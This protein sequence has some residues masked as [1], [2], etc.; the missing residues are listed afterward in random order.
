M[1][2]TFKHYVQ[3]LLNDLPSV[4]AG[5]LPL[6]EVLHQIT[7]VDAGAVEKL[8]RLLLVDVGV[9]V[10]EMLS[11][12]AKYEDKRELIEHDLT[13]IRDQLSSSI[14][15]VVKDLFTD[16]LPY[17]ADESVKPIKDHAAVS[18]RRADSELLA[19]GAIISR[20]ERDLDALAGL[21]IAFFVELSEMLGSMLSLQTKLIAYS[22]RFGNRD[23]E[24]AFQ[25][26]S[27][28]TKLK[29][30]ELYGQAVWKYGTA[31]PAHRDEPHYTTYDTIY[32]QG[33]QAKVG[34][35]NHE[36]EMG[37]TK[38]QV[39]Y[40]IAEE[41]VGRSNAFLGEAVLEERLTIQL[42]T[43]LSGGFFPRRD[44]LR[45]RIAQDLLELQLRIEAVKQGLERIFLLP[46]SISAAVP[47]NVP[48]ARQWIGTLRRIDAYINR[49]S[50]TELP[51]RLRA[52]LEKEHVSL[53]D[54][55]GG[56]PVKIDLEPFLRKACNNI[57]RLRLRGIGAQIEADGK[58]VW[59]G[60][61]HIKPPENMNYSLLENAAWR[62]AE[63]LPSLPLTMLRT[64]DLP[65]S[66][67]VVAVNGAIF[68]ASANG[69]YGLTRSQVL[70]MV[71]RT[72]R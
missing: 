9:F 69:S 66:D 38:T 20:L 27:E 19:L 23:F 49:L 39:H 62:Y 7:S 11:N 16:S 40:A 55:V 3:E 68:R 46:A 35:Q 45:K 10:G 72:G 26:F 57:G 29:I 42:K 36:I 13:Q 56:A 65:E 1:A 51:M 6:R 59:G 33:A 41:I 21:E 61:L 67:V 5:R 71:S 48:E 8:L 50:S 53:L 64:P 43:M 28:N 54:L 17:L 32:A 63:D 58:S 34:Q 30:G 18:W 24:L 15:D 4:A 22:S 31:L 2:A 12:E 60:T 52:S 25:K 70:P 37:L 47:R 14:R 44:V